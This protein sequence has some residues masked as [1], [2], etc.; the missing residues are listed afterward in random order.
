MA[1]LELF[2]GDTVRVKG[3]RGKETV[4]IVLQDDAT[5]AGS[6]KMNK[7]VRQNVGAAAAAA[8]RPRGARAPV[9]PPSLHPSPCAP[10]PP[11]SR[12]AC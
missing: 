8:P 3:K 2:R 4:C 9:L 6:V 11:P 10:S 5:D 1:E 7:V 12:R